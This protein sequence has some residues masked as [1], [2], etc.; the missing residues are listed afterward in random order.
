MGLTLSR[1]PKPSANGLTA[2]NLIPHTSQ[3]K[4]VLSSLPVQELTAYDLPSKARRPLRIES[5]KDRPSPAAATGIE[6]GT[7]RTF[8]M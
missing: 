5:N 6:P 8:S 3:A 2:C 1:Y 4:E 7:T